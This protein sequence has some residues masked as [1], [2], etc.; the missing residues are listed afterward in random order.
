[1]G[2]VADLGIATGGPAVIHVDVSLLCYWQ[3][4]RNRFVVGGYFR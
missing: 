2:I 3:G 1:M 4:P